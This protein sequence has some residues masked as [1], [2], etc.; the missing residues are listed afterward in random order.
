L[1]VIAL[2]AA[3][4]GGTAGSGDAGAG[5]TVFSEDLAASSDEPIDGSAPLQT[6]LG[7][8]FSGD[9]LANLD[10]GGVDGTSVSYRFL[11]EASGRVASVRPFIV[12]DTSREGYAAGTGGTVSLSLVADDG[13]GLPALDQVL[14]TGQIVM[15]LVDGRLPEPA[16][17]EEKRRQ[18]F[19]AIA[20]DGEPVTAGELYHIVFEQ[21]DPDPVNNYVGLDLLYQTST[22][23][24]PRPSIEDWGVTIRYSDTDWQEFT[25]RF[26][27]QLYTPIMSIAMEDGYVYGNGYIEPFP[28]EESYRPVNEAASIR[29]D[30]T[31]VVDFEA[32]EWWIRALRTSDGGLLRAHLMGT[33]GTDEVLEIPAEQFS[34]DTMRWV[35]QPW[36]REFSAG[37]DYVLTLSGA[38]GGAFTLF[39]LREGADY[40]YE[41]GSYFNG[42]SR[43]SDG[44]GGYQGWH[45]GETDA[46][47][48]NADVMMAW[49]N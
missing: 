18:N 7:N 37:V 8:P 35:S 6:V 26:G 43:P 25:T 14:A 40:N 23:L 17:T 11:A 38:D 41:P 29:V 16:D 20:L 1:A 24:G 21:V 15:D 32:S 22:E 45:K 9:T 4:C 39:P 12:V 46:S 33:D 5:G 47:F 42:I 19:S 31:P 27:E 13:T 10:V 30:F 44:E 28:E 36:A 48:V 49:T 34:T 2:L 3:S